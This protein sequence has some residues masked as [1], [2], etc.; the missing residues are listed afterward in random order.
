MLF[1]G[2]ANLQASTF[3]VLYIF[4]HNNQKT[5][6]LFFWFGDLW[7]SF[8]VV[9]VFLIYPLIHWIKS[10]FVIA[11]SPHCL[12]SW[13]WIMKTRS[14]SYIWGRKC[15]IWNIVF[16]GKS[17]D[18]ENKIIRNRMALYFMWLIWTWLHLKRNEKMISLLETCQT[19][20]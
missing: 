13:T 4:L 10:H 19:M 15:S 1:S 9:R 11:K 8:V 17:V 6:S 18:T 14:L 7:H 3:S 20:L 5:Q 2:T 12:F 16:A